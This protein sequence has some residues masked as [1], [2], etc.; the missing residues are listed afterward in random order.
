[1]NLSYDQKVCNDV[2]LCSSIIC[3]NEERIKNRLAIFL[4]YTSPTN[5]R[6]CEIFKVGFELNKKN[7]IYIITCWF[8]NYN[9]IIHIFPI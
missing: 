5:D 7:I 2:Y 6:I 4:T 3:V 9:I 8:F 1:M